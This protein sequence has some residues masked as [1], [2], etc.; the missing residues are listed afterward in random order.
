MKEW[1][2]SEIINVAQKWVL[3]SLSNWDILLNI[4]SQ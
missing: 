2:K 1:Y 4:S 3:K